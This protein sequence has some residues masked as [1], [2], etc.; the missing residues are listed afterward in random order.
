MNELAFDV[1]MKPVSTNRG[2]RIGQ[3][4]FWKTA[5][6]LA[7]TNAVKLYARRAAMVQGWKLTEHPVQVTLTFRFERSS[8][9]VDGCV[10]PTLDAM[11]GVVYENDRQVTICNTSKTVGKPA[12]VH[13]A[14]R[15]LEAP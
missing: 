12:G 2:Y 7:Y 10:K 14:I 8:Q 13:I 4:R 5:E 3:R 9:D 11:Q 6:F 1:P 15:G